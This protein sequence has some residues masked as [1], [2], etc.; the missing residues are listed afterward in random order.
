MTSDLQGLA[1]SFSWEIVE[2]TPPSAGPGGIGSPAYMM[3]T[4]DGA[5]L[6][7]TLETNGP[8]ITIYPVEAYTTIAGERVFAQV[9][10]LNDLLVLAEGETPEPETWMPLLPPVGSL[11]DRWVQYL[12]LPFTQGEGI[13]YISDS[14][15]R[16]QIGVWA[17]DT[18]DYYYQALSDDGRFYISMIWPVSTESLP[19]TADEAPEDVKAQATNPDSAAVYQE[20]IRTALNGLS[21]ADWTP[22]LDKL[23]ALAASI[24]FQP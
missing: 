12:K 6:T 8:R 10:Q 13:R 16:Q 22:D 9:A 4:F 3:V 5:T 21:A 20:S 7:E 11:M 18:T 23:D 15:Y 19:N 17:N 2:G 1:D 24:Q 14:P